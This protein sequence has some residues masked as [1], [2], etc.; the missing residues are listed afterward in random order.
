[1]TLRPLALL[2]V[3][4]LTVSAQTVTPLTTGTTALLQAISSPDGKV[5]WMSGHQGAVLRS[6]DGGSTWQ[7]FKVPGADSLQFRDVH[8]ASAD[9]AWLLSAGPGDASR[10]YHTRDGGRTWTMQFRNTDPDAFYD[11][12]GFFDQRRGVAF[13][14][15]SQ[16]RTNLLVT[17]D[18]GAT[19]TLLPPT[20]VPAP[21]EGEGAFAAS[22]GCVVTHGQR[23]G[24]VGLGGPEARLFRSDNGGA[25]WSVHPTPIVKA[26]SAG[27]TA[28]DFR[29]AE[30]GIAVGGRI[31]NYSS[32][33]ASAAVAITNDG[34]RNWVLA[35][36]PP[37]P[38]ALFG[39][40]MMPAVGA[41]VVVAAGPGGLFLTRD[42]GNTWTTL[43]E[44]SFWS[45][46]SNGRT[47]WAS[48]PRGTAV[49][50]EF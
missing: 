23:F 33:T 40:T 28:V 18:G 45:V 50:I 49:R 4:P 36:R 7:T 32:D 43:D 12:F 41:E 38:G 21:L 8:A 11:C 17:R 5:V 1:M 34:G 29:D 48:G 19:W 47:A 22:G 26:A 24:W 31:D 15:A 9:I 2:L 25:T 42:N 3:L 37:R 35:S 10:I 13:G 20:S 30:H 6:T 14:D 44:R 46:T 39:V 16:G 27:I